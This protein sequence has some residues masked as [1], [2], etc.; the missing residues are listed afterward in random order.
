MAQLLAPNAPGPGRISQ[1]LPTVKCSTCNHP[2]AIAELGEHV[3]AAVPALPT[4]P[5]PMS[6]RSPASLLPQKFQNLFPRSQTQ[7]A[8]QQQQPPAM[9]QVSP[10]SIQKRDSASPA[11]Q[12][13]RARTPSTAS[14]L[15]TRSAESR[16]ERIPS[17][18]ARRRTPDL[19]RV[20]FP[21]GPLPPHPSRVS[22]VSSRAS[23]RKSSNPLPSPYAAS[24]TSSESARSPPPVHPPLPGRSRTPVSSNGSIRSRAPSS[25]SM[26][27]PLPSPEAIRH[28]IQS[29]PIPFAAPLVP[30]S[31]ATARPRATTDYDARDSQAG[32]VIYSTGGRPAMP[33]TAPP[34]RT[35][36]SAS[37][38]PQMNQRPSFDQRPPGWN[39]A[40][41]SP[42]GFPPPSMPPNRARTP[43]AP[44]PGGMPP[45][46]GIPPLRSQTPGA[47]SYGGMPPHTG[48]PPLRNQ[49]PGAPPGA[50]PPHP[51]MPPFRSQTPGAP[52]YAPLPPHTGVPSFR[53]QT[54]GTP[55]SAFPPLSPDDDIDTKSGGEAGMAGVG[56]RGFAAAA[57]AAMFTFPHHPTAPVSE[58]EGPWPNMVPHQGMDGRRPNAP[59]FLDIGSGSNYASAKT[60]PLSADSAASSLSPHSPMSHRSPV[61]ARTPSPASPAHSNGTAT[62]LTVTSTTPT[63]PHGSIYQ[64]DR[65]IPPPLE[66]PKTPLPATPTTPSA[67]SVRLPFFEKFKNKLPQLDT[68]PED[69]PQDRSLVSPREDSPRSPR[70]ESE[71]SGLAYANSDEEDEEEKPLASSPQPLSSAGSSGKSKVRFPSIDQSESRYTTST[72]SPRPPMRSLSASTG[73]SAY[74]AR[75]VTK[76]TGALD[77]VMESLLED[78]ASPVTPTF[79]PFSPTDNPHDSMNKPPKLPTRS[80]TSPTLGAGSSRAV[81]KKRPTVRVCVK[82]DKTI[83]DGRWIQMDGGSVL[84]DRCWKNMYLPKCRRCNLPIEKQAVSSSDGQLKGKYHRDCFNCHTCHKPFPDKTFYVLDGKPFCAYHYHEANDSLCAA[85][86]CGQ[87]I[88]GPCAI[89]HDGNRYHP[90]HMLCEYRGCTERLVEYY[91]LDGRMLCERHVQKMMDEGSDDEGESDET[92]RDLRAQKRITRFIDLGELGGSELR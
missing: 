25:G 22:S 44:P 31:S 79:S 18:L 27:P 40:I 24:R 10:L 59:K 54:P 48:M 51:G 42:Y 41:P 4:P 23:S 81:P 67:A 57:R 80:H 35:P 45:H 87:P 2:V 13:P 72:A 73:A 61:L 12:P 84:C 46:I 76:S 90:E 64:R 68:T 3:C 15:S 33:M 26:H 55:Q 60:P 7:Q 71:Y 78:P 30:G 50:L 75:T 53:S 36:S 37:M 21:T 19:P 47:P 16:S 89:S 63:S 86:T 32:D 56:R 38:R 8:Q 5:P 83:E 70:S 52:Q 43:G 62:G 65:V 14:S 69:L 39:N 34:P 20:P 82:C 1:I 91:E 6:P 49:T 92:A 66:P 74:S 17:P 29:N 58:G 85:A 88:E 9:R 28:P 77:R 11:K